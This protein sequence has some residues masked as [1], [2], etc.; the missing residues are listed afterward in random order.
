M[1][2]YEELIY[3]I[4]GCVFKVFREM[5]ADFLEKVYE[6][7]LTLELKKQGLDVNTQPPH[8]GIV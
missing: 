4:R 5:D 3:R 6:K 2:E 7:A 1:L 8:K